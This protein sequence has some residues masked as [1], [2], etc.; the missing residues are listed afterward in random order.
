LQEAAYRLIGTASVRISEMNG[1]FACELHPAAE[2]RSDSDA[3]RRRFLDLVTDENLR[4]KIGRDTE[5]VRNIMLALAFG[6]LAHEQTS[7]GS[8]G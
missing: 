4:A 8:A 3:I 6:A 5:G 1:K 2:R 7:S